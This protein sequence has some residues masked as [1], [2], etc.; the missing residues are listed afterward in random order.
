VVVVI[1]GGGDTGAD[2]LGTCHRQNAASVHQFEILPMPPAA[3]A[4]A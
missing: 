2:C 4:G 3:P 1:M